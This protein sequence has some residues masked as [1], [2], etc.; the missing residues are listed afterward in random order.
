M[1]DESPAIA[2]CLGALAFLALTGVRRWAAK[3]GLWVMMML[4][5]PKHD[6]D[7][8]YMALPESKQN[9]LSHKQ[10]TKWTE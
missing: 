6:H 7:R 2:G 3:W 4:H 9:P 10:N 1:F 5:G 8:S